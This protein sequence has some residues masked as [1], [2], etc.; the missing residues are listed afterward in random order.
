[1]PPSDPEQSQWFAEEVQPHELSL[2]AYLRSKF[3][4]LPDVDDLVQET[5]ARLL[6]AREKAPVRR[7]KSMLFA[8]ARNAALDFFR[9]RRIVTI[10]SLANIASLPV[11]EDRPNAAESLCHDQELQLLAAAI[12][13]LPPRCR[14]VVVLRKLHGRSHRDIAQQLGISEHTVNAQLAI[15]VLRL[16]DYMQA[17]GLKDRTS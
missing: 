14:E 13:T 16:R 1:M 17:H 4:E 12:Q 15:G 5:Y 6:R 9:R 7:P 8:T 2:R 10:E 3:R 11:M